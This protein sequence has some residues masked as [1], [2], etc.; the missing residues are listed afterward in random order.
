MTSDDLQDTPQETPP[1]HRTT[2]FAV[3]LF[4]AGLSVVALATSRSPEDVR[5]TTSEPLPVLTT[6]IAFEDGYTVGRTFA[7]RVEARRESAVGFELSGRVQ[8]VRAEEGDAVNRGAVLAELDTRRLE[9]RRGELE[10]AVE[11]A[12][13]QLELARL[14][15]ERVEEA[16]ALDA[17]SPQ[18]RDEAALGVR[19]QAAAL[20]GA[21]ATLAT[22]DVELEKSTL[23]APY[24]ALIARRMVDEGQVITTGTP[25][26][27]L[28]ER[29]RPEVRI[30]LAGQ[31]VAVEVGSEHRLTIGER[32]F[33]GEVLSVLPVRRQG[34]RSIDALLRID[35]ELPD[36]RSG[37]LAHLHLTRTVPT[38]GFWLPT[39]ALT[40]GA[41]GLWAAYVV[42]GQPGDVVTVERRELELL[43]QEVDR[44]YLRGPVA[45]GERLVL[46]GLQRL[47]PDQQ[48]RITSSEG[49]TP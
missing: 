6:E 10:A 15:L 22:L 23:R 16:R 41:R 5:P 26:L 27:H 39:S 33:T 37:D 18:D 38:R 34:T 21:K 40:E 45:E 31:D 12:A 11:A 36:V 24:D 3:L 25:V 2:A 14:T 32:T 48:V 44:A 1:K 35:A 20:E 49:P 42:A 7:G 13:A 47:M 28:L 43:H 4:L 8:T 9:A 19:S 29:S 46:D 17:V 30:G